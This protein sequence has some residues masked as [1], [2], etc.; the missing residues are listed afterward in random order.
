M[1]N[2]LKPVTFVNSRFKYHSD[3]R[4]VQD[5]LLKAMTQGVTDIEELKKISGAKKAAEV[6]RSLNKLAIRREYHEALVRNKV[7]LDYLTSN[8]KSIVDNSGSDKLKLAALQTFLKSLGLEK[9]ES[10]EEGGKG[11]EELLVEAK[12]TNRLNKENS[13][14]IEGEL[15]AYEVKEPEIST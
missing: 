1:N 3:D 4:Y 14:L 6:Y 7:D 13:L 2:E 15:K 10:Q 9:Y 5:L 12:E 11:W 8:L